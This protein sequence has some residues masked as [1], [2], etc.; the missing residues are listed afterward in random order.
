[1]DVNPYTEALKLN[2]LSLYIR[3]NTTTHL[4]ERTIKEIV[5]TGRAKDLVITGEGGAGKTTM[6]T[7]IARK[8]KQNNV[9]V[10]QWT[11]GAKIKNVTPFEFF[12]ILET[13]IVRKMKHE[14]GYTNFQKW[15][16][17]LNRLESFQIDLGPMGG[18]EIDLHA[19]NTM[20]FMETEAAD[21][22]AKLAQQVKKLT[23]TQG[24]ILL[25]DDADN[26]SDEVF[27][28]FRNIFPPEGSYTLCV[29]AGQRP[30]VGDQPN[31]ELRKYEAR[32]VRPLEWIP[33]QTLSQRAIKQILD[34][35]LARH[36]DELFIDPRHA[37]FIYYLSGGNPYLALAIGEKC[38][39]CSLSGRQVRLTWHVVNAAVIGILGVRQKINRHPEIIAQMKDELDQR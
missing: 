38:Y 31:V 34:A 19:A 23:N 7:Y 22:F 33:I 21:Q 18:L 37:E 4:V 16:S 5:R 26:I 6:L 10:V 24:I 3:T 13:L 30:F 2:D 27:E 12:K 8:A 17:L 35:P 28:L 20:L 32:L 39:A 9:F 1:M 36:P 14:Y 25:L 11:L 29:A 15:K